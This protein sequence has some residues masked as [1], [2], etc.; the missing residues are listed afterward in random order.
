VYFVDKFCKYMMY[1]IAFE[2]IL[3]R[4]IRKFCLLPVSLER[5]LASQVKNISNTWEQ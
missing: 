2:R 3:Q 1:F 5:K 4:A